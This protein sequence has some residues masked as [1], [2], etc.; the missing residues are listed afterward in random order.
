VYKQAGYGIFHVGVP[1]LATTDA[2]TI[3]QKST[4]CLTTVAISTAS[5]AFFGGTLTGELQAV[6]HDEHIKLKYALIGT[7]TVGICAPSCLSGWRRFLL[8]PATHS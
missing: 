8:P 7:A 6:A 4:A 2:L 5:S 3:E 1:R